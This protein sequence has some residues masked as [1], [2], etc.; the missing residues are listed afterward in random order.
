MNYKNIVLIGAPGCGKTTIGK[1]L[2]KSLGCD[3]YDVDECIEQKEGKSIK[4]I[5]ADGEACFR[6][7]ESNV[8]KEIADIQNSKVI[9]TGGGVVKLEE[10]M[11]VF[12]EKSVIIF[13]NRPIEHIISDLDITKRPLL[14]ENKDKIYDL[15]N[16]RY[17]LYKKY[18]DHEI[19]NNH[20]IEDVLKEI[21]EILR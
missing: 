19:L 6:R 14:S 9:S 7:I 10:N 8:L 1:L 2:A 5:F 3:F 15:Y 13:I 18:C 17:P 4:D 21:L 16:E 11:K 12:D 20:Y